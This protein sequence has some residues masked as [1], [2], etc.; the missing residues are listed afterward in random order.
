LFGIVQHRPHFTVTCGVIGVADVGTQ[1]QRRFFLRHLL[2]QVSLTIVNLNSIG[3][4]GDEAAHHGAD[5]FKP[6]QKIRFVGDAV[7]DSDIETFSIVKQ[8]IKPDLMGC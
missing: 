4:R 5:I 7:I 8:S 1:H 3:L 2:Q 6:N